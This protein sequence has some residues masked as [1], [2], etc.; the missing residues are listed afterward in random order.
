MYKIH[1]KYHNTVISNTK[2]N[3]VIYLNNGTSQKVLKILY[4]K[5]HP[6]IYLAEQKKTEDINE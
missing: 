6:A 4:E 1:K 2:R 3:S 5:N